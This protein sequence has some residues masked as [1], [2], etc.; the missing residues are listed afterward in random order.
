MNSQKKCF[1]EFISMQLIENIQCAK[2]IL[3]YANEECRSK[4]MQQ[5]KSGRGHLYNVH[6]D[7]RLMMKGPA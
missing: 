6:C 2:A 1:E 3:Q 4:N 5:M 7:H